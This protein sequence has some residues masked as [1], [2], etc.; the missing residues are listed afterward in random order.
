MIDCSFLICAFCSVSSPSFNSACLYDCS[1]GVK[2]PTPKIGFGLILP[3]L[4][5]NGVVGS[6]DLLNLSSI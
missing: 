1:L 3:S 2:G 4:S 5:A 6:V